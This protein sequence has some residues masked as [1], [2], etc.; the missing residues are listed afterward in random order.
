MFSRFGTLKSETMRCGG[1]FS[2]MRKLKT[3]A[4][5]SVG[6]DIRDLWDGQGV[7]FACDNLSSR[8]ANI[9]FIGCE[10]WK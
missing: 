7:M 9:H 10:I 5:I 8:M 3:S 4:L 6:N 1:V 2:G